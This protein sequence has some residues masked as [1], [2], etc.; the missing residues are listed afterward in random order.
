MPHSV[1]LDDALPVD[2]LMVLGPV[3]VLTAD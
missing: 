1:A 2:R 3:S